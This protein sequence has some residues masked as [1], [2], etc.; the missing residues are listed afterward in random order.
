MKKTMVGVMAAA[1]AAAV[2]LSLSMMQSEGQAQGFRRTSDGKP[3]LNGIWQVLNTA[4][5]DIQDH[6]AEKGVPAGQSVVEGNEIP[7]K[8]WAAAKKREN[9]EMRMTHDPLVKCYLP[10]VPRRAERTWRTAGISRWRTAGNC[11]WVLL[12][13]G[14]LDRSRS[15]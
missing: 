7:Y 5:W 2:V 6:N 11:L 14:H 12:E 9:Y 15:K 10:G 4:S 8:P 3:D 1:A 13:P